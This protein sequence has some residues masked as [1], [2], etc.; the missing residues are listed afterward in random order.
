MVKPGTPFFWEPKAGARWWRRRAGLRVTVSH[1][2]PPVWPSPPRT[3]RSSPGPSSASSPQCRRTACRC[4]PS[5]GLAAGAQGSG[6]QGPC[7]WGEKGGVPAEGAEELPAWVPRGC[8]PTGLRCPRS[9]TGTRVS[10]PGRL[11][12]RTASRTWGSGAAQGHCALFEK[13]QR[14]RREKVPTVCPVSNNRFISGMYTF[15]IFSPCKYAHLQ[16]LRTGCTSHT[17]L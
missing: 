2:P 10:G 14:S 3:G 16:A 5:S 11:W 9:L 13:S 17:V 4:P 12:S 8:V 1:G 15:Q 7:S 6:R